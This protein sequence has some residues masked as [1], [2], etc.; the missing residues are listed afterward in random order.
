[1]CKIERWKINE[2][3][4]KEIKKGYKSIRN[5]LFI[6]LREHQDFLSTDWEGFRLQASPTPLTKQAKNIFIW[7]STDGNEQIFL[8]KVLEYYA[9]GAF[10]PRL[11]KG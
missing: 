1:M 5:G 10:S 7:G 2:K 9:R 6:G 4:S 11:D 3:M 8:Q